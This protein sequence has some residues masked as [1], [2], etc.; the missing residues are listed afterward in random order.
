VKLCHINRS[1][2]VFFE[3]DCRHFDIVVRWRRLQKICS[4]AHSEIS[5]AKLD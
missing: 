1:G 5:A 2:P 4:A 3:T